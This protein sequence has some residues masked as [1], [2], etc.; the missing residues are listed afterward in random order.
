M[1]SW[2]CLHGF[3]GTP[4]CFREL[5]AANPEVTLWT[6]E[7]T[8]HGTPPAAWEPNFEAEVQRLERWLAERSQE[9]VHLL[10]YSLGARL[11]L[12]LLA[13][14]R[15][16]FKSAVLIGANPGLCT[17]AERRERSASDERYQHVLERDGLEAFVDTWERLP[18][19]ASQSALA[20]DVLAKQRRARLTHTALGLSHALGALG[21]AQMPDYWPALPKLDLPVALVVGERDEKFRRLAEAMLHLL[22]SARLELAPGVGHNVVLENPRLLMELMRAGTPDT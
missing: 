12:G 5:G 7:L 21:L 20:A 11:A 14:H 18:L 8:G 6:P 17:P 22:P 10:G 4:E 1:A 19:F 2:L 16:R 9:R 3:S 13:S 15:D